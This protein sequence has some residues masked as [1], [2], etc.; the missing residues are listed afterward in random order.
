MT[1]IDR[2]FSKFNRQN[3]VPEEVRYHAHLDMPLPIGFG[4]SI[5]E[6]TTVAYM[7]EWLEAQ[8]GDKV[9]DLGSGSGWTTAL[10]SELVGE[11]GTVFA[12]ERIPE[13]VAFGAHNCERAGVTNA[14]FFLAGEHYGL[15]QV[16]PY[17]RILVN[18]A[19]TALPEELLDQ[20]I[21]D[22][23][24]VI[25]VGEDVLEITKLSADDRITRLHPGFAFVPLIPPAEG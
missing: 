5:S 6:P 3:F 2:A 21:V 13:L 17:D 22:G 25:P 24:L 11:E 15:P 20:L 9:L 8:P 10:L 19:A 16:A 23:K 14:R 4:Q 12:V 7:L 18:A 1:S